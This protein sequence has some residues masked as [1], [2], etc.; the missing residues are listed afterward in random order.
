MWVTSTSCKPSTGDTDVTKTFDAQ[1]KAEYAN[2]CVGGSMIMQSNDYKEGTLARACAH[3][4]SENSNARCIN[5]YVQTTSDSL[6]EKAFDALISGA[7]VTDL[8]IYFSSQFTGRDYKGL[9]TRLAAQCASRVDRR[10]SITLVVDM[11]DQVL[12]E[13]MDRHAANIFAR[14]VYVNKLIF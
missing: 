1:Q 3:Q 13:N 7:A 14:P 4:P 11:R 9:L 10:A 6:D 12:C 2:A 5:A 8:A